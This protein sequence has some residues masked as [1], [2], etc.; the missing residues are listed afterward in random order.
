MSELAVQVPRVTPQRATLL[1]LLDRVL[2]KGVVAYGDIVLSI[3]DLDLVYL[4][5]RAVLSSIGTLERL[6]EEQSAPEPAEG[7]QWAGTRKIA[8]SQLSPPNDRAG[9]HA[10]RG[11]RGS[12]GSAAA[13]AA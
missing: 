6:E 5:L 13:R 10:E 9:H 3:A 4:N 7:S 11:R 8:A 1:D 2:G 12:A